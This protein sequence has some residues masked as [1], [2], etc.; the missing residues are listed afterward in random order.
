MYIYIYSYYTYTCIYR[1]LISSLCSNHALPAVAF[2]HWLS[3]GKEE[4]CLFLF[5]S[6][7]SPFSGARFLP[8]FT[9]FPSQTQ[10]VGQ[11]YRVSLSKN[12]F[13]RLMKKVLGTVPESLG[14]LGNLMIFPLNVHLFGQMIVISR[15][16]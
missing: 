7:T 3:I 9:F 13:D 8:G 5:L 6:Y 11:S 4:V 2:I 12:D 14:F 1:Q 16:S 10:I 15:E